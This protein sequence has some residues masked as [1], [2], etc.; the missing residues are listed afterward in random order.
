MASSGT[1][2]TK[3]AKKAKKRPRETSIVSRCGLGPIIDWRWMG[4]GTV[5]TA[6]K[7]SGP[8]APWRKLATR[9]FKKPCP[10]GPAR[11]LRARGAR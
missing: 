2:K 9:K 3:K 6:R 8:P 7:S 5:V 1:K 4:R 11:G 10:P